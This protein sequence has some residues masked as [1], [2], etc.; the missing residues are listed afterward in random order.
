M[1]LSLPLVFEILGLAAF[2]TSG[3]LAAF[4]KDLDIV[5]FVFVATFTG[6]G[7]GTI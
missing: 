2:A 3:A 4:N 7:G 1:E 5:G 6:I